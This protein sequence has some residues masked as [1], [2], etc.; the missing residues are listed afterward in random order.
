MCL[1]HTVQCTTEYRYISLLILYNITV[2]TILFASNISESFPDGQFKKKNMNISTG[3]FCR[4]PFL[5]LPFVVC[6]YLLIWYILGATT[7]PTMDIRIW[8][9]ILYFWVRGVCNWTAASV[10]IKC[11]LCNLM[12]ILIAKESENPLDVLILYFVD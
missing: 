12:S 8:G 6:V 4:K 3:Y 5:S 9:E 1:T 11:Y 10:S 2:S 7:V